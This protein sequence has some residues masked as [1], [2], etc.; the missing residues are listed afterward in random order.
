MPT[1]VI[2]ERL[3]FLLSRCNHSIAEFVSSGFKEG[4]PLHYDVD[5][6]CSEAKNLISAS[7]N[8]DVVDAKSAK[9]L[10]AGRLAGPFRTRPFYPFRISPLSV[11]P[12]KT[13]GE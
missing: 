12:K 6:S 13:P 5:P 7:E 9:E 11:V 10:E 4:F 1:P 3:D 8:P 2:V